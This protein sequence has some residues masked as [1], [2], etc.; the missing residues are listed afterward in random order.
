MR[1]YE[2]RGEPLSVLEAGRYSVELKLIPANV[3]LR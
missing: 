1:P 2:E 3:R